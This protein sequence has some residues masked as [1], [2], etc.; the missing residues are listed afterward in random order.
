M[1]TSHHLVMGKLTDVLTGETL[2][3]THDERLRQKLAQLLLKKGH[4][5]EDIRPRLSIVIENLGR[6]AGCP[7]DFAVSAGGRTAM[8]LRYGPGSLVTRQRSALAASRLIVPYQ[9]P[10]VVVSNGED[11]QV[12]S[13]ETGKVLAEG[14]SAIPDR[15]ELQKAAES[16]S[17]AP[18][19]EKRAEMERRILFTHDAVGAC[20][21]DDGSCE[22]PDK[23]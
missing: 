18:I 3:D 22:I 14:L 1:G 7:V 8:I 17:F 20:N 16:A 23:G 21:C 12:L 4:A 15:E 10:V 2:D 13:G 19:S 6:S 5:K 9:V 11:A